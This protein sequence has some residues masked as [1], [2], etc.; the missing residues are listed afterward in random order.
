M[1]VPHLHTNSVLQN[2]MQCLIPKVV[3]FTS[4]HKTKM[5]CKHGNPEFDDM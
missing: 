2:N 3:D 4:F 5:K 1:D